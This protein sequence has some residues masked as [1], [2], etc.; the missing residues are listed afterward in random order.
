MNTAMIFNSKES[1]III[2]NPW[3]ILILIDFY[4]F[5]FDVF[6]CSWNGGVTLHEWC[7]MIGYFFVLFSVCFRKRRNHVPA[8]L[9]LT[10]D[11]LCKLVWLELITATV[12]LRHEVAPV[13]CMNAAAHGTSF[14]FCILLSSATAA[15]RHK[16]ALTP[17]LTSTT[18]ALRHEVV[19]VLLL[20]STAVA[21]RHLYCCW[22]F[23]NS[24]SSSSYAC[25]IAV[26]FHWV[27]SFPQKCDHSCPSSQMTIVC[28]F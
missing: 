16:V 4:F 20:T 28:C 27:F 12:A 5:A 10:S 9:G 22:P 15:L 11:W 21:L 25:L 24:F 13:V 18:V 26:H 2:F 7:C 19:L 14:F 3:C 8:D 6:T 23:T 17:L 1:T